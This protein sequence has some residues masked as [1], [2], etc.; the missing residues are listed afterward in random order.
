MHL[1]H[2]DGQVAAEIPPEPAKVLVRS[3]QRRD[4]QRRFRS[5]VRT[6]AAAAGVAVA[7]RLRLHAGLSL[8]RLA[9]RHAHQ[10]DRHRPVQIR[11]VQG[12]RIDQAH[13]ESRLLQEGPAASRRHRIH[14]H[15]QPFD[16]DSRICLR[17]V[18][19]DVPDRSV[20]PAAQGG[21]GAGAERGLRGRAD[22][23]LDQHHRQ[24]VLAAVR[25][26]R[27]PPRA[28]A[29]AGS[30]GV[31]PDHVRGAGRYR[32]HHAAGAGRPVGDAEGNAGID[33]RLRPRHQRQPGRGAQADAEG[34]LRPGQAPRRQGRRRATFR[35]TAIPPS[36]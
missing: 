11:R 26:S 18:R 35:S 2:A 34:R 14:H 31:R 1:R 5:V 17:Q 12:Q 25:Q 6:E 30:Q 21:Q 3:G 4:R 33:P 29:G 8:P 36:S 28:G 10:A 22:Q 27:H 9:G 15:H 32:R 7:A 13:E 19:H 20:D 16:G 24:L 23:R